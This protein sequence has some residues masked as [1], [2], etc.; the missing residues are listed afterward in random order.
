MGGVSAGRERASLLAT[1]QVEFRMNP[2]RYWEMALRTCFTFEEERRFL[3][4]PGVL[5]LVFVHRPPPPPQKFHT[6]RVRP[7]DQICS[8]SNSLGVVSVQRYL[9]FAIRSIHL[10]YRYEH[11]LY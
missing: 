7:R 3:L 9:R 6:Q 5:L 8:K 10:L 11:K 4:A 1:G 2:R